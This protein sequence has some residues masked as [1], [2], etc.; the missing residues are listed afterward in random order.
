MNARKM[1]AKKMNMKKNV[2]LVFILITLLLIAFYINVKEEQSLKKQ[3]SVDGINLSE[4]SLNDLKEINLPH[5]NARYDQS[6]AHWI[7]SESK[8]ALDSELVEEVLVTL[9]YFKV[10]KKIPYKEI[11]PDF[12]KTFF[13]NQPTQFKLFFNRHDLNVTI[14]EKH[15]YENQFY[16][17]IEANGKKSSD[18]Y[19]IENERPLDVVA[20]GQSS[21]VD[22]KYQRMLTFLNQPK[23][24]FYDKHLFL[25][26]IL[27]GDKS[28]IE[29]INS[30]E[31]KLRDF[32]LDLKNMETI[33]KTFSGLRYNTLYMKQWARELKELKAKELVDLSA[34]KKVL[35]TLKDLSLKISLT[36]NSGQKD[37]LNVYTNF[38][39]AS[40]IFLRL[41][42][43]NTIYQ[44]DAEATKVVIKS[45][46]DF[47]DKKIINNPTLSEFS[48]DL[49]EA[50]RKSLSVFIPKS[51]NVVFYDKKTNKEL[52]HP[53]LK[54][55][56]SVLLLEEA[57]WVDLKDVFKWKEI[58]SVNVG[59]ERFHFY[60]YPP[61]LLDSDPTHWAIVSEKGDL[62]GNSSQSKG[63]S[64]VYY[65]PIQGMS[66]SSIA[67]L[68]NY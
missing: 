32:S 15:Q 47:W 10:V 63:L 6:K 41:N 60:H 13:K 27:N 20:Q 67:D 39:G 33:P 59:D 19:L 58:F 64:I 12:F 7:D 35:N 46:F 68:I 1:N 16:A 44:L 40:G 45:P 30:S 57:L 24:F 55:L 38:K 65:F 28:E 18:I 52:T 36:W 3:Y 56:L 29:F 54:E 14:G 11:S 49:I 62:K 2:I 26:A 51:E 66:Y 21:Y 25:D 4:L 31:G 9:S 5:L 17:L 61:L 53:F 8:R 37:T 34:D 22:L 50:P 23:D 42:D 43:Q 48:F